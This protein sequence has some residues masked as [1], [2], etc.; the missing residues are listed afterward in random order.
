[1]ADYDDALRAAGAEVLAYKYFGSYQGD[2]IAHV[3]YGGETFYISDCYGSCSACDALQADMG[4]EPYES[5]G[6]EAK[7]DWERRLADFGA[8]YLE[9]SE[10]MTFEQVLT[11]A[12]SNLGWD[13]DAQSMVDWLKAQGMETRQGGNEVPSRSDDSPVRKDAP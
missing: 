8:R 11:K 1:M 13:S 12:S 2:W 6:P 9:P 7:A 10:R 5:D 3:R 4:W